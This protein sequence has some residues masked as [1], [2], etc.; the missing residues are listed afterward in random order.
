MDNVRTVGCLVVILAASTSAGAQLAVEVTDAGAVNVDVGGVRCLDTFQVILPA[1]DW[2]GG[3]GPRDCGRQL[4]GPGHVRV[5]GIMADEKPCANFTL[6]SQEKEGGLDLAWEI[7]FTRD[8]AVETIRL[9]GYLSR[10]AAAGKAA[11]FVRRPD[12]LKWSLF[13]AKYGEPGGNLSDWAFDWFGWVLPGDRGVRFRPQSG[14]TDMYLQDGRQWGGDIFQTCWTLAG[15]GSVRQ[16]TV[17]RCAI[18]IEPLTGIELVKDADRLRVSL[19]ALSADLR[20]APGGG[21]SGRIEVRNVR[22]TEETV[23]VGWAVTDDLQTVLTRGSKRLRVPPL[24]AAQLDVTAPATASGDYRLEAHTARWAGG[25]LDSANQRL[26]IPPSGPRAELTL[27]G[28]WQLIAAEREL[29]APPEGQWKPVQVPGRIDATPPNHY[30]YRRQF[31]VPASMAGKRLK[32]HFGAVNHQARVFVN[33]RF[34]GQHFG[35]NLPFDVDITDFVHPDP[36]DVWVAVTD[37]TAA[38]T[39]PPTSFELGP[40]EHPGWKLLPP[41]TIIA[42]IGGDFRLTGIWQSVTLEAHDAAHIEDVVVRTSVRRHMIDVQTAIRNE[43][44]RPH[45]VQVTYEIVDR[46]GPVKALAETLKGTPLR[47]GPHQSGGSHVRDE[48]ADP[49]LWSLDD[50]HLYRLV[51]SLTEDG[52]VVDRFTTRFGFREVWTEGPRFVL[53]GVPMKLF[54]TSGWGMDTWE[55]AQQHLARMKRAGTRCM[56]LHTQ[57][58]QEHILDAADELGMLIVDE[59]AVYCYQQAYAT[60]DKRFWANYADHV[61][62]LARRDRNHPSL[63]IYSLEN[64]ILL[65]GGDPGVWETQLG[66]LADIVREVDPTRLVTCEADLDP[67]GKMDLIGIHYPREYWAGFTLYPGKCWWMDQPI[68]YLGRQWL[69]KRDKPLYIGE[70]DGGFPAWYPQYQAF[71]LGDEAYTSKGRFSVSSPNSR[72]RREMIRTEVMAYRAYGVTGLNP[73]FDPDEVEVFGPE[74]YAPIALSVREQTHDFYAGNEIDRTVYVCND[75]SQRA[76]LTLAWT[77]TAAGLTP[78]SGSEA[79]ELPPCAVVERRVALHAPN[80]AQRTHLKLFLTLR[81]GEQAVCRT[82]Q[83]LSIF[84]R[85]KEASPVSGVFVHDLTGATSQVLSRGGLAAQALQDLAAVP[86]EARVVIIGLRTL[87]SGEAP[88]AAKLADFVAAGGSVLC[89]EQDAYPSDWLPVEVELDANQSHTIAF[90]R[91]GGCPALAHVTP[92]DLRFW[93]PDHRVVFRIWPPA[94]LVVRHSLL[95]PSR[96]NFRPLIDAGGIRGSI[97]D[98][99]GLNWAPL[100]ELPY[101]R[102]RYVLCQLLLTEKAGVEP[103]ADLL[104]R[105]LV[106][107]AA[108]APPNKPARVALLADPDS[109]LKRAVDGMGL[110]Y[111]SVLSSLGGESLAGHGLLIAGGGPAAWAAARAHLAELGEWVKQ[112]GVLWLNRVT[113]DEADLLAALV[114]AKCDLRSADA[115]PICLATSNPL[116][117]G[118]S[119]HELY[120]RDRPIWDQWTAMR[121]IVEFVPSTLPP[122]AVALTDPPGLVKM[123]VGKG[124]VLMNQLLW[125][126]TEQNRLDGLK[127]ASILLTNLS[128]QMDLAPFQPVH[129]ED[130]V[131]VDLAAHCNLGFAGDPGSGWMD[132]GPNALAGFP[133]GDQTLARARFRIVDAAGNGGKSVIALRGAARAGY[134]AEVTGIRVNARARAL[135]FLHACA[136]GRPDGAQAATYVVHYDDGTEQRIPVRVGVEIADWYVD[137]AQLPS[138]RVAWRGH[139]ADKPGPIG[140]YAMRWVNPYPDK[141]ISSIDLISAQK[142]P[143]TVVMAISAEK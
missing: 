76:Q 106:R 110:A 32:L 38:C 108:T 3:A 87:K 114:G 19:L 92:E 33:Q 104:L 135:H 21:A 26:L 46:N 88:W 102:G 111:D 97:D 116:I 52:R 30:W 25:P 53:N 70:F 119:N 117:A 9:N 27:D 39:N 58:W 94:H 50:P 22:P 15:K 96:G 18:R 138:A 11:W 12:G 95:K 85:S 72:A 23:D 136:W 35:G 141:V 77:A 126:S 57:P 36:N 131:P 60:K 86:K 5:T 129:A 79:V 29:D 128:A 78:Q 113:P 10:E 93:Q 48:W 125:D 40:F 6:D 118:L 55:A 103:M 54:A 91:A 68:P 74:A 73:W 24:A 69:W 49:H 133:L 124:L 127:I 80:V 43:D 132:H 63:A 16:G 71:W 101:G 83:A 62:A 90:P 42:P 20:P 47:L 61:R 17:L 56:R 109:S 81:R 130:F 89:L 121:R 98:M 13:P 142:D 51:V 8:Y 115:Q 84:P 41:G 120:W 1:P 37:W 28:T 139:I 134:P 100:L 31:E 123:P 107:Y 44:D 140:V 59:A 99:N 67:A 64:E 14:L 112:G 137:P 105:D 2:K 82:E 34:A 75:S 4:L 7:A 143:V 66:R 65:C 122:G 45:A